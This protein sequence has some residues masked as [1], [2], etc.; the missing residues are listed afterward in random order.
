MTDSQYPW[1]LAKAKEL[2][3]ES[4]EAQS[5][6]V[7]SDF[8]VDSA[9]SDTE[10][11]ERVWCIEEIPSVHSDQSRSGVDVCSAFACDQSE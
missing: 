11:G 7:G 6:S 2:K 4:V 1:F 10:V 8:Q 3:N 5:N 9:E